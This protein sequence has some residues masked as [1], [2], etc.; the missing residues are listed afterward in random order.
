[1]T[2]APSVCYEGQPLGVLESM[3]A[4]TPVI[5]SRLGGLAEIIEDGETG[6]LVT[7]G[8]ADALAGALEAMWDDRARAAALG[9]R[10]WEFAREHF[11]PETQTGR[12]IALYE[13]LISARSK[14][15][16]GAPF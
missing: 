13:S 10:A 7:P 12:L 14:G 11:T 6:I 9:K 3:A 8:D 1:M 4:G 5:A 16:R 15:S 2:V